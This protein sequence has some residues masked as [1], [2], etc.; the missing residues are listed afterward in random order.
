VDSNQ[1]FRIEFDGRD[2]TG[3]VIFSPTG[4]AQVF[5]STDVNVFLHKGPHT[6]R[7]LMDTNDWSI[8]KLIFTKYGDG[9]GL[10][11]R[12]VW[13]NVGGGTIA[14]LTS[15]FNY[16]WN[17]NTRNLEHSFEG[18]TN[19][20]DTSGAQVVSYG[21]RIKGYLHPVTTGTYYFYIA[22]DDAGEL[23]LSTDANSANVTKIC[24]VSNQVNAYQWDSAAEQKSSAKTL[25]AGQTYYIEAR[26]KQATSGD[27]IA[28]GWEGPGILRQAITGAYL[29]PYIINFVDF[30]NFASQWLKTGCSFFNGYCKGCDYDHDGNVQLDDLVQFAANWWLYGGE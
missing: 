3:P 20:T 9:T 15:Y 4:G 7:L 8:D 19:W 2:E 17:P 6:M 14:N 11:L 13:T 27:S 25:V 22:S 12:E 10:A 16:P 21:T 28:I 30:S 1:Q 29:S 26:H 18:P 23:W 24:Q 5:G